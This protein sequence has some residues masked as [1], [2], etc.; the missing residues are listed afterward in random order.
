M[1]QAASLILRTVNVA[2]DGEI[3]ILKMP[4][5]KIVDLAK[6]MVK[7]YE[8]KHPKSFVKS[9]IRISKAREGER[10]NEFL[11]TSNEIPFCHD[12]KDVFKITK[13][14]NKKR[15]PSTQFNSETA[16]KIS[17]KELHSI[18]YELLEEYD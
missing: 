1:S 16:R 7:V 12:Q 8:K 15:I 10:I 11:I 18:I 6:A 13:N 9:K 3:F 5:V 2:I 17:Q 14:I 4:A